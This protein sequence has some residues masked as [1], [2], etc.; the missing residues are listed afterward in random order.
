MMLTMAKAAE[1]KNAGF[2]AP[3][4]AGTQYYNPK[5]DTQGPLVS[6]SALEVSPESI[7][8]IPTVEQMTNFIGKTLGKRLKYIRPVDGKP[9]EWEIG[10]KRDEKGDKQSWH[11]WDNLH[12]LLAEVCLF[13]LKEA[14]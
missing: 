8:I 7:Y 9:G 13:V 3:F 12:E 6:R 11:N 5:A 2:L 14:R 1:L 10:L 4:E